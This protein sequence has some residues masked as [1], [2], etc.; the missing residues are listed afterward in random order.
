MRGARRAVLVRPFG[1]CRICLFTYSAPG[2]LSMCVTR[3]N[4]VCGIFNIT[5]KPLPQ[6]DLNN[7]VFG[8]VSTH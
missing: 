5:F 2:L 1:T 3:N 8:R 4:E 7:V 6:F